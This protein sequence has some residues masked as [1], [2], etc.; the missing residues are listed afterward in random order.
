MRQGGVG[1]TPAGIPAYAVGYE[2][3]VPAGFHAPGIGTVPILPGGPGRGG[4]MQVG[5]GHPMFGRG[6]LGGGVGM[7]PEHPGLPPGA[8]WDPIGPPGTRGFHPDDFQHR[9]PSRPHPDMMQP[10]PGRGTDWDSFFG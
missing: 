1:Y 2:D 10:G 7:P 8:R 9:D 4:G 5:P 6:K 3:V